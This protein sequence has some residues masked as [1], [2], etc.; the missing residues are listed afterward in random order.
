MRPMTSSWAT[1]R[2]SADTWL[3][4]SSAGAARITGYSTFDLRQKTLT[5]LIPEYDDDRLGRIIERQERTAGEGK[6]QASLY[7]ER[8]GI[9]RNIE[10]AWAL[11]DS[12]AVERAELEDKFDADLRRYRELKAERG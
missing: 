7:E 10:N 4:S 8:R 1:L 2:S 6:A 5:D 11:I 12:K 3:S 9:R